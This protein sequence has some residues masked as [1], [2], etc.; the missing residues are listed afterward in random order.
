M[1]RIVLPVLLICGLAA[2]NPVYEYIFSEV[3]VAPDSLERV[4]LHDYSGYVQ[5]PLDLYGWQ[6]QTA[7]G[8]CTVQTHV[9]LEDSTSY[10]VLDRTNLGPRFELNDT[11]DIVVLLDPGN[12][13]FAE[14]GYPDH[15]MNCCLAPPAGMSTSLYHVWVWQYPEPYEVVSWYMDAT[16]TFGA[17][18]DDTIGGIRGRVLNDRGVPVPSSWVCASGA[19]G[20]LT[21]YTN[22]AGQY[23]LHPAG[24]GTYG[25]RAWCEG[26]EL[27]YYPDS[28]SLVAN[29][30]RDSIDIVIARTGILEDPPARPRTTIIRQQGRSLAIGGTGESELALFDQSGRLVL[31]ELGF[32]V[33]DL[34]LAVLRPGVYF[35]RLV[36]GSNTLNRKIVLY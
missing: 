15:P 21:T 3:Q 30:W 8:I 36:N 32:G 14:A 20:S 28:V 1:K 26:H 13:W 5:L 34:D 23:E 7:A 17:A 25:L 4:E 9:V 24:P 16:P 22:S 33:W 6:L 31:S 27:G 10:A 19:G 35:A 12:S 2:A 11:S 18:N 29:E